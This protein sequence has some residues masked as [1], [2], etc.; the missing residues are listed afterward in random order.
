M[1][2]AWDQ[3]F[4]CKWTTIINRYSDEVCGDCILLDLA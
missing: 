4:W 3:T 1:K 2:S